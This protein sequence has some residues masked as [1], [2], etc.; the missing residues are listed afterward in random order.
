MPVSSSELPVLV[1]P[2]CECESL[3]A[4]GIP[5]AFCCPSCAASFFEKGVLSA[6]AP[7]VFSKDSE[8]PVALALAGAIGSLLLADPAI[9]VLAVQPKSAR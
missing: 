1:C 9:L 7:Q 3:Q 8:A 5:G 2:S 4:T 6:L